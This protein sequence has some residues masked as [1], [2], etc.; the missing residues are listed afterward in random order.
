MTD[1]E[2]IQKFKERT[3]HHIELVNKYAAKIDRAY[4]E[5]DNSKLGLLLDGYKY[6]SVPA[7]ER[8]PE[9]EQALDLATFIH[10]TNSPH[11][12][13]Y[14]TD[15][16][17]SGF[18]RKKFTPNGPID[19][20]DMPE[21]CLEEMAVD[22]CSCGEEFGNTAMSWFNKV[23]GSRWIFTAEQQQFLKDTIIKLEGE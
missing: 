22:W 17:L 9:Q 20:T 3:L 12:P 19:A 5:H 10:I 7:E 1:E 8:T 18:T 6:F 16:P 23:N 21:E 15:T 4:P 2:L 14:W 11:H 13:E